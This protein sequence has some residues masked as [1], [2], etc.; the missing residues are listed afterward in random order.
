[1][2]AISEGAARLNL[3]VR[4]LTGMVGPRC[5]FERGKVDGYQAMASGYLLSLSK[6]YRI[7]VERGRA[8]RV[9]VRATR[10]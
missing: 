8:A 5:M 4:I 2:R 7:G 1:M 10:A 6:D 3:P 9:A